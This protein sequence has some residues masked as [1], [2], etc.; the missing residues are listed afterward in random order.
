VVGATGIPVEGDPGWAG[1]AAPGWADSIVYR[2]DV[3][4]DVGEAERLGL[5]GKSAGKGRKQVRWIA[6]DVH[7]FAWSTSPDYIYEGGRWRD[8]AVHV[9]YQPGDTSWDRGQALERTRIALAWLDSIYGEFAWPQITN[10]HRIEPGGTEFPM[11]V[12]DGSASLGLILHEVGHN[13]TM[14]ILANN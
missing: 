9:L 5:L 11:M 10:V 12:M 14:G 7:N 6:K 2:R 13:Y 3:Y 1:A 4:G 8:L